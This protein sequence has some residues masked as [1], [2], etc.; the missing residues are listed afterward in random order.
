MAIYKTELQIPVSSADKRNYEKIFGRKLTLAELR[1]R[2]LRL[3]D[4]ERQAMA[5][6]VQQ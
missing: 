2:I 6:E 4:Q 5:G 3:W 1:T